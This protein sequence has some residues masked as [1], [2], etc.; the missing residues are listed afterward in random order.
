MPKTIDMSDERG[1]RVHSFISCKFELEG[2]GH[3]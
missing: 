2:D 1:S 3:Q